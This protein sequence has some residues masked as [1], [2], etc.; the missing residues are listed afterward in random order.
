MA[1]IT[2]D[3]GQELLQGLLPPNC[4]LVGDA[5]YVN[6]SYLLTPAGGAVGTWADSYNFHQPSITMNIECALEM[7]VRRWGVLWKPLEMRFSRM[8]KAIMCCFKLHNLCVDRRLGEYEL[9]AVDLAGG[10]RTMAVFRRPRFER[11]GVPVSRLVW[12]GHEERADPG[13]NA[14]P[15]LNQ[16]GLPQPNDAKRDVMFLK[17]QHAGVFRPSGA[18]TPKRP[19]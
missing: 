12:H 4:H 8:N 3:F 10:A 15:G 19:F 17:Y 11:D 13:G 5:A 7:L 6:S 14:P 18:R 2:S 1:H 9:N 16:P